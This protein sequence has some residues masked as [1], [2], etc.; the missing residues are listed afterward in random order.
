MNVDIPEEKLGAEREVSTHLSGTD[1]TF[2]DPGGRLFQH[3]DRILREINPDYALSTLEWLRSPV[4]QRWIQERRMAPTT[5]L[6]SEPGQLVK[7]EHERIFFPTYPWEWTPG[8]WFDAASLTL[9]LCEEALDAGF[10]LK[11]A[12]PLNVLFSGP[13]P[14][15]VDVLS[16]ETRDPLSPLW[17][18]YGQFI[19][20]FLLPLCAFVY[21]G[22]PLAATIQRRDGYEPADLA[23]FLPVF[24]RWRRP[25]RTLV[26]IPLL[27]E[28]RARAQVKR[29]HVPEEVSAFAVRRLLSSTR[30]LL[31]ALAPSERTSRW[32][33]YTQTACHYQASDHDAKQAFVRSALER[34]R[35]A[36][37]LDVGANTGVYSRIAVECGADVVAWDTDVQAA[38][39]NWKTA[40][41]DGL[42]ILPIVADFARPTPSA[43]WQNRES[44]SLLDRAR[45]RFDCVLMLGVLHH[46]LVTDQIPLAEILGQ[47]RMIT[48]RWAIIEWIPREDSQFDGLCRGRQ[49]LYSHLNE[50]YFVQTLSSR[51]AVHDC[52]QLPNGRS[53]WLV[54]AIG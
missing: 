33:S 2:R 26:T 51:F 38:D 40:R 4:A 18:A 46:L 23:P 20:T 11:D 49:E 13:Q 54:E 30:K 36:H 10:I 47:L 22:W 31:R 37:V 42:R 24:L 39:L 7:L 53:L 27:L 50:E 16:F 52:F 14:I 28:R 44:Q 43:G 12:T 21:L 3:G 34:M 48:S 19:R 41:R 1:G 9:D 32:S 45:G 8:Q 17:I 25:V 35:P 6:R 15:F 5:V 29:P